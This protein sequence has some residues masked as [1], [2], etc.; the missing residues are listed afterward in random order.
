M[1]MMG[2]VM[3]VTLDD[4]Y[5]SGWYDNSEQEAKASHEGSRRAPGLHLNKDTSWST[6]HHYIIIYMYT[7]IYI[8]V[9]R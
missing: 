7:Y 8:L 2:M 5:R 9:Y 1:I 4:E 3:M 6:I